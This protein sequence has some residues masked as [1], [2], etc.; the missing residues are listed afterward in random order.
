M[1]TTVTF[2]G[3]L[4]AD[5]QVRFT[6]S[7]TQVTGAPRGA[8]CSDGGGRPPSLCRRSGRVKLE[9]ARPGDRR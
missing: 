3:N 6:G 2:E 9:A 1:R 7:G 8:D 5:T 4:A